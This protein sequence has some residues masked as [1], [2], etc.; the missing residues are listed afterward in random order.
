MVENLDDAVWILFGGMIR[1]FDNESRKIRSSGGARVLQ[2]VLV[3]TCTG[4]AIL[5][6][7][8]TVVVNLFGEKL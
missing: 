3:L 5:V 2:T 1:C 8:C 6:L 4:Q 7:T